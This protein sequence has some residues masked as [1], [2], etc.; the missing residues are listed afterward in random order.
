MAGW[1]SVE[2]E[3]ADAMVVGLLVLLLTTKLVLAVLL[4]L[5][6]D[7]ALGILRKERKEAVAKRVMVALV[8]TA[9]IIR[10]TVK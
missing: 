9:Y 4:L 6:L 8:S 1:V 3:A 7:V 5:L 2:V 10:N